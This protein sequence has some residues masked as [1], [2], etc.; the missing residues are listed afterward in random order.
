M[1]TGVGLLRSLLVATEIS[2]RWLK[3]RPQLVA[4][5]DAATAGVVALLS[6]VPR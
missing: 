6:G 4:S 3:V 5:Y 2:W 1:L